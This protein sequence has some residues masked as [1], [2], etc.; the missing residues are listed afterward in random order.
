MRVDWGD[1]TIYKIKDMTTDPTTKNGIIED[2][3][4]PTEYTG[5]SLIHTY[6]KPGKY[7]V[8]VFG[9]AFQVS[10]FGTFASKPNIMS[11]IL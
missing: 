8:K 6:T 3:S 1:G 7:I 11:R 4:D 2:D 5:V 10:T 9:P